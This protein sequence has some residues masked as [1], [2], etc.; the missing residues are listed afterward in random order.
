MS[1]EAWLPAHSMSC[2]EVEPP[3][4]VGFLVSSRGASFQLAVDHC[5]L[6]V[7][8]VCIHCGASLTNVFFGF[9]FM[10]QRLS[11]TRSG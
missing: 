10:C 6:V 8:V 1:G 2:P 11:L 4:P 5:T 9:S 3:A 7:F